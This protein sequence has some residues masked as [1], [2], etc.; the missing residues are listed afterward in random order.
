VDLYVG[1]I[2]FHTLTFTKE[3]GVIIKQDHAFHLSTYVEWNA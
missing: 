1:L 2:P 3:K